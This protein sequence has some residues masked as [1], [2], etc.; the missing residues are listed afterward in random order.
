MYMGNLCIFQYYCEIKLALKNSLNFKN[1]LPF[2]SNFEIPAGRPHQVPRTMTRAPPPGLTAHPLES[3]FLSYEEQRMSADEQ[4][5]EP[6]SCLQ[7][8]GS[9]PSLFHPVLPLPFSGQAVS[10]SANI[11]FPETHESQVYVIGIHSITQKSPGK[12]LLLSW[13]L[14]E[15]MFES[16]T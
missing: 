8:L 4:S 6:V 13:L 3:S 1:K 7:S 5:Y 12:P 10:V 9:P 15:G 11:T 14:S 2:P 16:H